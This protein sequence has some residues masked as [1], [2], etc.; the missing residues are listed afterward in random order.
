[1]G[2]LETVLRDYAGGPTDEPLR[3]AQV[4]FDSS[5][6]RH[7]AASHA[8]AEP[9]R[10]LLEL[11][12]EAAAPPRTSCGCRARTRTRSARRSSCRRTRTP[13]R[14]CCTRR[15][16]RSATPRPPRCRTRG[17][18]ARSWRSRRTAAATGL[19]LDRRMGELAPRLDRSRTLYRGLRPEAM[20][21]ALYVGAT[22]RAMSGDPAS[23]LTVTSTVRDDALPA[24]ARPPQHRGDPQLLAAHDRLGVRRRAPLLVET[25][26]PRLPVRARPPALAQPDRLGARAGGHPH[27]RRDGRRTAR[28]AAGP[29]TAA[30]TDLPDFPFE[31]PLPR[32][33][34]G[35]AWPTSTR[36]TARRW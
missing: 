11:P 9:R 2:N 32:A 27:H 16:R 31:P 29:D 20:A 7:A 15:A 21:M 3:Y 36:A 30:V 28:A 1:M 12:V 13:P 10:R 23:S 24:A 18:P 8:P 34:T 26:G 6:L 17:T 14:R 25:A 19:R 35:C 4:Y 5:P 22:V 33:S